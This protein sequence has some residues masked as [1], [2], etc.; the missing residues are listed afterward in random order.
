MGSI[1]ALAFV[2]LF[3]FE[4]Y[5]V[6]QMELLTGFEPVTSSLPRKC[7]TPELQE[8]LSTLSCKDQLIP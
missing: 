7:S 3:N 6:S 5:L 2:A 8:P 1:Q 4:Y